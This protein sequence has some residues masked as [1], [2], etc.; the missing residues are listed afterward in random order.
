[1]KW[2][3]LS[4]DVQNSL[5]AEYKDDPVFT[6][7]PDIPT[8]FKN[9]KESKT[10]ASKLRTDADTLKSQLNEAIRFP[11]ED[12]GKEAH[13]EFNKKM[14]DKSPNL[15]IR[16]TNEEG[17]GEVFKS[18]GRPESHEGYI[19]PDIEGV[20]MDDQRKTML[21]E[22]ALKNNM[23]TK[24]FEGMA[25]GMLEADKAMLDSHNAM[26][27]QQDAALKDKWGMAYPDHMAK[28]LMAFKSASGQD[29]ER[30]NPEM[31]EVFFNVSEQ[32]GTQS[33]EMLNQTGGGNGR[34]TPQEAKIRMREIMNNPDH[35]M[36]QQPSPERDMYL[37]NEWTQ[38]NTDACGAE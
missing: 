31:A 9:Y 28:A 15:M 13:A 37:E 36:N 11:S 29:V 33:P 19:F 38:L 30:L 10:Y 22:L 34:S 12:A 20:A 16:P 4:E 17:Y 1:M 24:Q 26:A 8:L 5:P 21:S 14:V 7:V 6:E 32:I 18:M 2:D 25:Q 3:D 23:T 35:I 27:G